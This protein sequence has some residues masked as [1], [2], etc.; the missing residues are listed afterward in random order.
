ML[1]DI[2]SFKQ[3][4]DMA[5]YPAP[6]C[7]NFLSGRPDRFTHSKKWS[8]TNRWTM[9]Q[10][11]LYNFKSISVWRYYLNPLCTES[12]HWMSMKSRL[13]KAA[14]ETSKFHKWSPFFNSRRRYIAEIFP[15]RLKILY[16]QSINQSN[17]FHL[18]YS[19]YH[20]CNI[21]NCGIDI[22]LEKSMWK[23]SDSFSLTASYLR[24]D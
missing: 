20:T 7:A 2:F 10:W 3:K 17:V 1:W 24:N 4:L 14:R 9:P 8:R 22:K 6:D 12:F 15:I 23:S 21:N 11:L 19:I 13:V 16:N 18:S 5:R